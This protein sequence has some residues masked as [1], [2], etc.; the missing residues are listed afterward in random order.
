MLITSEWP[1]L[2]YAVTSGREVSQLVWRRLMTF[3]RAVLSSLIFRSACPL[4]WWWPGAA[5][6]CLIPIVLRVCFQ[7]LE[8]N[9][10]SASLTIEVGT[11]CGV[12]IWCRSHQQKFTFSPYPS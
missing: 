3:L 8:V 10:E 4:G 5:M 7:N 2:E 12:K 6:M 9:R 11:P 1:A